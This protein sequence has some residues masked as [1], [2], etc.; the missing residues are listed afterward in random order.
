LEDREDDGPARQP[1]FDAF[2]RPLM[3]KAEQFTA[4]GAQRDD[5]TDG[6]WGKVELSFALPRGSYATVLL[7]ALGQ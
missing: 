1:N 2:P 3:L 6:N 5:L 7:R 4:G